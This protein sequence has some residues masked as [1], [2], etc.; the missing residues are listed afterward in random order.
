MSNP[1][2]IGRHSV[3]S[4]TLERQLAMDAFAALPRSHPMVAALEFD[5]TDALDA[6][7]ALRRAG[8]RVSL[9][10][11]V[12]RSIAVAISEHPDLN[13]VRHGRRLARFD[14]V[15]V[16]VPVEV[17]TPEG[18]FPR[19][20]VLRRAQSSSAVELFACLEAARGRQLVSGET[21]DEDRWARR[22]MGA[23]RWL[24]RF[25]RVGLIRWIM[26][27]AFRIKMR[28]GTTLVTSVGKFAAI[29]GFA[30]TFD[31]GPR[32]ATFV[33]GGVASKPWV[34]AGQVVVRSVLP[35]SLIVDHDLVDGAPV[36]RFARRLQALIESGDG[37]LSELSEAGSM[38]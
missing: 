16:S 10:A 23:V 34:H 32:A 24:P 26:R 21:S 8:R 13:L 37:L 22:T 36:A 28:A 4:L 1:D 27:S 20:V 15:D 6:I 25:L 19:E 9:F 7:D 17:S 11:F 14:D 38:P 29:P 30:F 3:Q 31:T 18:N 33:V 35:L 5:V 2:L 12:V